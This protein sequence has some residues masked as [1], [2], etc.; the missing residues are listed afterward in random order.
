MV[1][2]SRTEIFPAFP[3]LQPTDRTFCLESAESPILGTKNPARDF[4][5]FQSPNALLT[6]HE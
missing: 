4:K 6:V 5:K 1:V 3:K 2:V